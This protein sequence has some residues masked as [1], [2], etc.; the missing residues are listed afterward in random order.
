MSRVFPPLAMAAFSR[1]ARKL[2]QKNGQRLQSLHNSEPEPCTHTELSAIL[3]KSIAEI[4]VRAPLGYAPDEGTEALRAALAESHQGLSDRHVITTAGAQE[5]LTL[6]CHAVLDKGDKAVVITP[7]FEPILRGLQGLGADLT[8][9]ALQPENGQWRLDLDQLFAAM[10]SDCRLLVVNFPHNPTGHVLPESDWQRLIA[11]CR[12]HGTWLLSDEVFRGLEQPECRRLPPAVCCY[13]KAISVG[14]TAKSLALPGLRV[15]WLLARDASFRLKALAIKQYL[16]VCNSQLDEA[17]AHKAVMQSPALWQ[18]NRHIVTTN[19]RAFQQ[20]LE[21]HFSETPDR[22]PH[23]V[24]PLGGNTAFV[25][26]PAGRQTAS[27]T[28]AGEFC[29]YLLRQT[30]LLCY[31]APVFASERPAF[32]IGFGY[33]RFASDYNR[34]CQALTQWLDANG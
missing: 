1:E 21:A 11:H 5:A 24:P 27:S 6:A 8:P 31:P 15:G 16:S 17:V 12:K 26:L 32:R 20:A 2:A 7:V 28:A 33:R 3:G 18:R 22:R 29:R 4:V 30:G 34:L 25:S 19:V 10:G 23:F 9:V 13:D 14:V